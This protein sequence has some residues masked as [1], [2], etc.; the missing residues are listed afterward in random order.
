[1]RKKG[2]RRLL[3]VVD[4]SALSLSGDLSKAGVIGEFGSD[5]W[6]EGRVVER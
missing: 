1:M 2:G 3:L 6:R 4:V 5:G